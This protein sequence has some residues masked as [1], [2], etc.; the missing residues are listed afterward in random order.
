M[1]TLI[2]ALVFCGTTNLYAQAPIP[3]ALMEAKTAYLVNDGAAQDMMDD[4]AKELTKWGRFTL[5]DSAEA[6]DVTIRF[7]FVVIKGWTMTITNT[8]DESPLWSGAQRRGIGFKN[9][10]SAD[11]VKRLRNLLE[12][13]KK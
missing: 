13:K 5:V 3:K 2:T 9:N 1:K 6:S 11:L 10:A 12:G 4:L 7:G 8:R